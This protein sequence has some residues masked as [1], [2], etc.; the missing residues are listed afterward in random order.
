MKDCQLFLLVARSV[1]CNADVKRD[2]YEQT[3]SDTAVAHSASGFKWLVDSSIV[4]GR[5]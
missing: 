1:T 2:G 5:S 4:E 3:T